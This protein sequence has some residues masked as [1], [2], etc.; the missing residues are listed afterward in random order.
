MNLGCSVNIVSSDT[1]IAPFSYFAILED[2]MGN[3][4]DPNYESLAAAIAGLFG[5][6]GD[7]IIITV[8]YIMCPDIFGCLNIENSSLHLIKSMSTFYV[9]RLLA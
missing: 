3:L 6:E 2:D 8:N 1:I 5:L 4:C 9:D 7:S